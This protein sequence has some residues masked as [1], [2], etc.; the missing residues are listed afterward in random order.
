MALTITRRP[1]CG[2]KGIERECQDVTIAVNSKRRIIRNV[3][4]D[5]CPHCG[6]ELYDSEAMD[7]IEAGLARRRRARVAT[8]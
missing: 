6:E 5:V 7:R 2:R 8:G 1:T 3:E 4:V